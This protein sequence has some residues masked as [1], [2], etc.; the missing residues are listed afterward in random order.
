MKKIHTQKLFDTKL[1]YFHYRWRT[2]LIKFER[3]KI[4]RQIRRWFLFHRR[5]R[6]PSN[7]DESNIEDLQREQ[8]QRQ[9]A[10]LHISTVAADH[11][12]RFGVRANSD[13]RSLDDNRPGQ[14][15]ASLSDQGGQ[16]A[17]LQQL[18]RRK[19]HDRFRLSHHV[20]RRLHRVRRPHE[21]DP[22]SFQREQ[23]HRWV[24]AHVYRQ[25]SNF[26]ACSSFPTFH[27]FVFSPND[28]KRLLYSSAA[29]LRPFS[30]W[31][32]HTQVWRMGARYFLGSGILLTEQ[33]QDAMYALDQV[34]QRERV[35]SLNINQAP[36]LTIIPI[37]SRMKFC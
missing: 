5:L 19:L 2:K 23:T 6:C 4:V 14:G 27:I 33:Q 31:W 12:F 32:K 16:F 25:C 13:Q 1:Y 28:F 7:E 34:Y 24:C 37:N 20:D 15:D 26:R 17:G 30:M 10:I 21:K 22:G 35:P 8:A 36:I 29:I 9:E 3:R 11:M 18:R